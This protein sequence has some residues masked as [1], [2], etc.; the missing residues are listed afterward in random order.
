MERLLGELTQKGI[1]PIILDYSHPDWNSL[2]VVKVFVPELSTP[3]LQSRPMLGHPRLAQL[4]AD[5]VLPNARV[6]PLPYP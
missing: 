5:V 3:F 2:S 6:A 4:R 1:D